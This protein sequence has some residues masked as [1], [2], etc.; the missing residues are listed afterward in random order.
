MGCRCTE[1]ENVSTIEHIHYSRNLPNSTPLCSFSASPMNPSASSQPESP[2]DTQYVKAASPKSLELK[3]F[4]FGTL[5]RV[6]GKPQHP[7]TLNIYLK[8]SY[9]CGRVL[10]LAADINKPD[11]TQKPVCYGSSKINSNPETTNTKKVS[12]NNQCNH[13]LTGLRLQVCLRAKGFGRR[14][15]R[16]S[17]AE[18]LT[19][20]CA[21]ISHETVER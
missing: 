4:N 2:T 17:G 14:G 1:R 9:R 8:P 10:L 7:Q 18:N 11:N 5:H 3:A 13:L 21:Y 12:R 6:W 19:H 20:C 15:Y 16:G